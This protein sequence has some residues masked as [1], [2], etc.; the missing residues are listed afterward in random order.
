MD[1]LALP[2]VILLAFVG[3]ALIGDQFKKI[4]EAPPA[5][6]QMNPV[7]IPKPVIPTMPQF[8]PFN[9]FGQSAPPP[10]PA[11]DDFTPTA[12]E[13]SNKVFRAKFPG[14]KPTPVSF[15]IVK[16]KVTRYT[17]PKP[18][19]MFEIDEYDSGWKAAQKTGT[20]REWLKK[21]HQSQLAGMH[22]REEFSKELTVTEDV[23][24]IAFEALYIKDN[25]PQAWFGRVYLVD[26]QLYTASV[27]GDAATVN[28]RAPAFLDSFAFMSRVTGKPDP[29]PNID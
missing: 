6:L 27:Y 21:C 23:P 14:R 22:A 2:A 5:Q 26:S 7:V 19:L 18:N 8:K 20:A 4:R 29:D 24:G 12:F 9:P 25:K 10:E 28:L 11:A 13:D 1:K 17:V 16:V 3:Y 15:P